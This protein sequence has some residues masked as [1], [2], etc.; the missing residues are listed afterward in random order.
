MSTPHNIMALRE[1]RAS[2]LENLAILLEGVGLT[3]MPQIRE[4]ATILKNKDRALHTP[5]TTDRACW[6]YKIYDLVVKLDKLPARHLHPKVHSI[7]I[8]IDTEILSKCS[9]WATMQDPLLTMKFK[10]RIRGLNRWKEYVSGFHIDKH[11]GTGENGPTEVHPLYH[12]QYNPAIGKKGF[13]FGSLLH[14]DIPRLMHPPVD[15]ILGLDLVIANFLPEIWDKLR[16]NR[17]YLGLQKKYQDALWKPYMHT[18]SSHWPANNQISID[19]FDLC[20]YLN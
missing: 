3:D 19:R 20:P 18:L 13:S 7:S 16:N 2:D 17:N 11:I 5:G 1:Q 4:A 8:S 10:V 15:L 6:G 14:L 12:L 9:L